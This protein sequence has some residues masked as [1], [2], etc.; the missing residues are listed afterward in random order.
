MDQAPAALSNIFG[1]AFNEIREEVNELKQSKTSHVKKIEGLEAGQ[2]EFRKLS[3]E[4]MAA[5]VDFESRA[6]TS[7]KQLKESSANIGQLERALYRAVL[8][9]KS[10]EKTTTELMVSLAEAQN[11]IAALKLLLSAKNEV[12][13]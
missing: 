5:L 9:A 11:E 10:Q 4:V 2:N 6:E 13:R 12:P 3:E 8:N 7:E 1:S